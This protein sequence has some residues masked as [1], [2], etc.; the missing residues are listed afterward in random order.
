MIKCKDCE[1]EF[2]NING[3]RFHYD[4]SHKVEEVKIEDAVEESVVDKIE[5]DVIQFP[6]KIS[7]FDGAK[8]VLEY[9]VFNKEELNEAKLNA[10][11]KK[12]QIVIR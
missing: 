6:V 11:R 10:E 3:L 4:A 2:K 5:D 9:K 8:L 7:L 12:F 1:R